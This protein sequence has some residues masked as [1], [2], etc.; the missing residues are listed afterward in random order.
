MQPHEVVLGAVTA[1]VAVLLGIYFYKFGSRG[2]TWKNIVLWICT[3]CIICK[4]SGHVWL[5]D[6][7]GAMYGGFNYA[8]G[9]A[10]VITTVLFLYGEVQ[11]VWVFWNLMFL[12]YDW[13]WVKT[14]LRV[15]FV[16]SL[17]MLIMVT[18][19]WDF[20][21]AY[22]ML[23]PPVDGANRPGKYMWFLE[24]VIAGIASFF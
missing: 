5:P 3:I 23:P 21:K 24:C 11:Y 8:K 13:K 9:N 7:A 17:A 1:S 12:F 16:A 15:H 14:A 19:C 6:G 22:P 4:A 18:F 2:L 20:L 10:D